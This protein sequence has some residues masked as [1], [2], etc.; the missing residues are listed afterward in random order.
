MRYTSS[1]KE[2]WHFNEVARYLYQT[3][4]YISLL[5][6]LYF[7]NCKL[8][9]KKKSPGSWSWLTHKRN[10]RN[11]KWN[12]S[13]ICKIE[14]VKCQCY[15]WFHYMRGQQYKIKQT[16][17]RSHGQHMC[18]VVIISKHCLPLTEFLVINL[19]LQL[20]SFRAW[21]QEAA[22][23][24]KICLWNCILGEWIDQAAMFETITIS[25]FTAIDGKARYLGKW[26][27]L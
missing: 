21:I 14:S 11:V 17:G 3:N 26:G 16:K 10:W 27:A 12:R 20:F 25:Q 24:D 1:I 6:R 13:L 9:Q 23:L 19:L 7:T 2:C 8:F 15:T 18:P 5:G 22:I 4:C